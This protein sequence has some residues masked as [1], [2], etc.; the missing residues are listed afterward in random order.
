MEWRQEWKPLSEYKKVDQQEIYNS[1]FINAVIDI[2]WKYN[3]AV[4]KSD[5][6]EKFRFPGEE[7]VYIDMDNMCVDFRNCSD[8][9]AA[10]LIME[11]ES[12]SL[13]MELES[14]V[15]AEGGMTIEEEDF[16]RVSQ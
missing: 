13:I 5:E 3:F 1:R 16:R 6:P 12:R 7:V 4:Q 9:K 8:E 10:S 11:L 15:E 2:A 14:R